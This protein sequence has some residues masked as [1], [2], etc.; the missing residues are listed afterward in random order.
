MLVTSIF[1]L[2]L[3][4]FIKASQKLGLF[5]KGLKIYPYSLTLS[6]IYSHFNTLKKKNF[7]KTLWENVKLLKMSN[8]TFFH[9]VFYATCI[10]KSFNS[11]NSVVFCSFFEFGMISKW[12]IKEWVK[13]KQAIKPCK[14]SAVQDFVIL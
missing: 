9:N 14:F 10:L 3:T 7:R 5:V 4:V 11:H 1:S 2:S 13:D 8:F 12:C 6:S